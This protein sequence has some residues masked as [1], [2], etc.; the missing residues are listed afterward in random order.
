VNAGILVVELAH[1]FEHGAAVGAGEAVP[2]ADLDS[3][4]IAGDGVI[5]ANPGKRKAEQEQRQ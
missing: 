1:Q 5:R 2:I 3:T 4:L